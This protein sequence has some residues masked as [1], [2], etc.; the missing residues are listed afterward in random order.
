MPR[1]L[2]LSSLVVHARPEA[3]E[4]VVRRVGAMGCEVH[5]TSPEG[6]IVVTYETRDGRELGDVLTRMQ[7]LDGVLAAAMVY[8]HCEPEE[9]GGA[10]AP[11]DAAR[12]LSP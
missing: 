10:S 7:L 12:E 2:H 4:D 5:L 8:H 3:L 11:T 9:P 1:D 6:K